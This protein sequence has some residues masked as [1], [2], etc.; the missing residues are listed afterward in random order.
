LMALKVLYFWITPG[1]N[2]RVGH[3]VNLLANRYLTMPILAEALPTEAIRAAIDDTY[4]RACRVF[5]ALLGVRL[6]DAKDVSDQM[7]ALEC[8]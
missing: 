5:E 3:P 8:Q 6:R 1:L 2:A 4:K 7:T